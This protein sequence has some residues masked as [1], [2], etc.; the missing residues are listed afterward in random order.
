MRYPLRVFAPMLSLEWRMSF[1]TY[2]T[3]SNKAQHSLTKTTESSR[4]L[5]FLFALWVCPWGV[6]P[7]AAGPRYSFHPRCLVV[8]T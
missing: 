2:H 8:Y 3:N 7:L 1:R 6:R 5:L 4:A